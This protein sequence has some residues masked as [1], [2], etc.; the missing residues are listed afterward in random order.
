MLRALR[1]F[2]AP[3]GEAEGFSRLNVAE[4]AKNS[5]AVY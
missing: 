2:P 3:E 4:E 5:P 1:G